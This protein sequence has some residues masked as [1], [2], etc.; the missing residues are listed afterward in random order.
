MNERAA[1]DSNRTREAVMHAARELVAAKGTGVSLAEV[2]ELAGVSKGGLLHHFPSRDALFD[3]MRRDGIVRFRDGVMRLVDLS[4]NRPGKILRAYIRA[5][6]GGDPEA[7]EAFGTSPLWNGVNETKE[8]LEELGENGERWMRE[9]TADGLDEGR[10]RLIMRAA[11]GFAA[12]A[13]FGEESP[14]T[15]A[16]AR[17]TLLQMTYD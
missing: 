8:L 7:M 6:C 3:A 4:E 2:A 10:V 13:S 1:R 5:L 15:L 16:E 17:A 14:E 11:E 12:A 9:L